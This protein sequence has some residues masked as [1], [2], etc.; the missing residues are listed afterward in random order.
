MRQ[1]WVE[2]SCTD[3]QYRDPLLYNVVLYYGSALEFADDV[4]IQPANELPG[5][6]AAV[7]SAM[8]QE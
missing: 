5:F 1:L 3:R 7:Q 2:L 8:F 4:I 6:F